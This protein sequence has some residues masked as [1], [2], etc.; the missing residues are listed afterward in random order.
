MWPEVMSYREL[1]SRIVN[2]IDNDGH[3]RD[4][5]GTSQCTMQRVR[6]QQPAKSLSLIPLVSGESSD[7]C[8]GQFGIARQSSSE[9]LRHVNETN[10]GR[11]QR[12]VSCHDLLLSVV[13][14]VHAREM[15]ALIL[16]RLLTQ[17][18]IKFFNPT[19]KCGS[20]VSFSK[21][22]VLK[23]RVAHHLFTDEIKVLLVRLE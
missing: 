8:R 7:E 22:F 11:T 23:E 1:P 9:R 6:Q 17:V 4:L 12:R 19:M 5:A 14:D 10:G 18:A 3:R 2:W 21:R 15:P 16:S 13:Q 20:A